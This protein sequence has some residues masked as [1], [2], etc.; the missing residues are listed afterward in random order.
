MYT[1]VVYVYTCIHYNVHVHFA[2]SADAEI[3]ERKVKNCDVETERGFCTKGK[4]MYMT[5]LHNSEMSFS[6]N[7]IYMYIVYTYAYMT[8]LYIHTC[9]CNSEMSI[10]MKM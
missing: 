1:H 8:I 6:I 3:E 7:K 9:T 2:G 10:S 4:Y 5:F